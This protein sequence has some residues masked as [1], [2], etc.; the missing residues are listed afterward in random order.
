MKAYKG[1]NNDMTCNPTGNNPFQYEEGKTYHTDEAEL[2]ESGFHACENPIDC[3]SYYDPAHSV[4]HEVELDDVVDDENRDDS[5]ICGKTIKIGAKLSIAKLVELLIGFVKSKCDKANSA[6][7]DCSAN[8]ATGDCS[9][10]SA[11]GDC[12]AN[13]A[14]GYGSANSATGDRSANSATGYGSAN[15]S[16]GNHS[17]NEGA[18][19]TISVG[20][21]FDN[22]CRGKLG[23]YIVL[24]ERGGWDGKK[25]PQI[26]EPKLG[27]ID[28]DKLKPDVWYKLKD[29]EFVECE[30]NEDD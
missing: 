11:T 17:C 28:G 30:E 16:V 9:A 12:S 10:N 26:G 3:L 27:K 8:S 15:I 25:F 21:G 6:T 4:Y 13:S 23:A 20:W 19:G 2:C 24:V 1:F 14:T 22:R 5:K 18:K 29:G 7:G